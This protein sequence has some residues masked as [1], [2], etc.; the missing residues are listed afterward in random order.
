MIK[1]IKK[2]VCILL[3][4]VSMLM[5]WI[6]DYKEGPPKP[7]FY[8]PVK[9]DSYT[10]LDGLSR[11]QGVTTDG[12]YYYFSSNFFLIKTELDAVTQVASNYFAI[13]PHLLAKGCKHIG[14]ITY[15][16]GKIYAPVEDSKVFE[17]LYICVYDAKTL[18]YLFSKAV[19]LEYHENGIPWCAADPEKGLIYSAGRDHITS[20]NA[21]DAK[22]LNFVEKIDFEAPVHKVQGGEMYKGILYLSISRDDHAVFA[23]DLNRGK[24][25][26]AFSRNLLDGAEGEGMTILPRPDGSLFHVLDI[27]ESKLAVHFRHYDFNPD[28][29]VW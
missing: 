23:V 22:T 25:R 16:D 18:R 26:K 8:E 13:P 14:G 27:S 11:S 15:Y 5:F 6:S 20:V 9:T 21:Y 17:N 10:L 2:A 1:L 7:D 12:E 4:L 29:I 19:P 24:V 28:S 3:A